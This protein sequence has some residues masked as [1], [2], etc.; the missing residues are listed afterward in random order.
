MV[1]FVVA[2]HWRRSQQSVGGNIPWTGQ[3]SIPGRYTSF[4]SHTPSSQTN[5]IF[6]LQGELEH[7]EHSVPFTILLYLRNCKTMWSHGEPSAFLYL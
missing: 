1:H 6:G 2:I 7:Q 5:A 3:R 4:H